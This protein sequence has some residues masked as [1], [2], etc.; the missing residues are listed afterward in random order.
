MELTKSFAITLLSTGI[1][2]GIVFWIG[3]PYIVDDTSLYSNK[4]SSVAFVVSFILFIVNST[5]MHY[6]RNNM[7][8]GRAGSHDASKGLAT[9][10]ILIGAAMFF[11]PLARIGLPYVSSVT[12]NSIPKATDSEFIFFVCGARR[13]FGYFRAGNIAISFHICWC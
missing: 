13:G 3:V 2:W 12:D 6:A 8:T 5:L 11:I 9:A 7:P 4:P 1:F 10:F